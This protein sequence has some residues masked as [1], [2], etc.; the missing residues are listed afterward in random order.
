[1]TLHRRW[2]ARLALSRS[3]PTR[4][5][6]PFLTVL[7]SIKRVVQ[8]SIRLSLKSVA[9]SGLVSGIS[10]PTLQHRLFSSHCLVLLASY[11]HLG[12]RCHSPACP[13]LMPPPKRPAWSIACAAWLLA[14]APSPKASPPW[15]AAATSGQSL[16]DGK[17]LKPFLSSTPKKIQN[18]QQKAEN[19]ACVWG[20]GRFVAN[21]LDLGVS[22]A[23]ESKE[24]S[25]KAA[26][27]AR[28]VV[29]TLTRLSLVNSP[30]AGEP[31]LRRGLARLV[32]LLALPAALGAEELPAVALVGGCESQKPVMLGQEV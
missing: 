7:T 22:A 12:I 21:D 31:P 11:V 5:S 1:M 19:I 8:K 26:R 2:F 15:L 10:N 13:W 23:T 6:S 32:V 3:T 20:F 4:F 18:P 14:A 30:E 17:A 16:S 29:R 25:C 27:H 9:L 24:M 28:A